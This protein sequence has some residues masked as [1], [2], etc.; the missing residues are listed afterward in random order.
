MQLFGTSRIRNTVITVSAVASV[1]AGPIQSANRTSYGEPGPRSDCFIR[2]DDPHISK[3]FER[4]KIRAVKVNAISSCKT[5]H[6]NV[7]LTVILWKRE[8]VLPSRLKTFTTDPLDP[9]SS[10]KLVFMKDAA[11]ECIDRKVTTY[12]AFAQSAAFVK[13]KYQQTPVAYSDQV[14]LACGT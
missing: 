2:V 12:Y 13:G 8:N 14:A 10:K 7:L 4:K 1:F 11:V 5:G 9:K 3:Y 6:R